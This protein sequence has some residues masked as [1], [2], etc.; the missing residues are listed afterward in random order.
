[1]I[2]NQDGYDK[3]QQTGACRHNLVISQSYLSSMHSH[4]LN[5]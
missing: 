4:Y 2:N 3:K 1:M 5:V